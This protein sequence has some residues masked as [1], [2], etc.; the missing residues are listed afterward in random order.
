MITAIVTDDTGGL[1][2]ALLA[3]ECPNEAV[4]IFGSFAEFSERGF[5]VVA[6]VD[7]H[8]ANAFELHFIEEENNGEI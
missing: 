4:A 2:E 3:L 8:L 1:C 5:D 7:I 6:I